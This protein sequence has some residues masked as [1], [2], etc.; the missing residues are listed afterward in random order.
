MESFQMFCLQHKD[1]DFGI[2]VLHISTLGKYYLNNNL[3]KEGDQVWLQFYNHFINT[4]IHFSCGNIYTS[5]GHQ[6]DLGQ[7]AIYEIPRLAN[8]SFCTMYRI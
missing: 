6:F 1:H 7:I 3:L 5:T 8:K 4:T 2:G